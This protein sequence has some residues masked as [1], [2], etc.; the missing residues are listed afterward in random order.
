MKC[1]NV[2]HYGQGYIVDIFVKNAM[3]SEK[4]I[5]IYPKLSSYDERYDEINRHYCNYKLLEIVK[6]V[7]EQDKEIKT[8]HP[9]RWFFRGI[10]NIRFE[11]YEEFEKKFKKEEPETFT[12]E[13]MKNIIKYLEAYNSDNVIVFNNQY[14]NTR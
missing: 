4:Q 3:L 5:I 6:E 10:E 13:T 8:I 7:L 9:H 2:E 1:I 12:E 11:T 14:T